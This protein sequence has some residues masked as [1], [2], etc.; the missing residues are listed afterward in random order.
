MKKEHAERN[1][2]LNDELIAGGVYKDWVITTA[3]YSAIHYVEFKMFS[4]AFHFNGVE[5]KNLEEAHAAIDYKNRKSRHETRG[6]LVKLKLFQVQVQYDCLRK[7]SQNARY[8]DYKVSTTQATQAKGC[9]NNIK[10]LCTA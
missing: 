1:E 4:T 10:I 5:V 2:A 3:F 7:W 8:V 6:N 9:L